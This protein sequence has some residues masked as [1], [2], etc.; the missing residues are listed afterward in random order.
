M[1]PMHITETFAYRKAFIQY[2]RK[3]T[4]IEISLKAAKSEHPT[5]HYIWRTSGDDKV[6]P[7]H[8]A[9]EGKI[10]AG[11]D[12]PETGHPGED[13]NCRCI[14]EPYYGSP[15]DIYDPPIEPVYP[16]R[17]IIPLLRIPRLIIAWRAWSQSVRDSLN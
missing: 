16:E 13:Y 17:V 8:A 10:F 4:P 2:L 15:Y 6:R 11:E 7:S 9:N 5:S 12:P 14:A 1:A 3:G